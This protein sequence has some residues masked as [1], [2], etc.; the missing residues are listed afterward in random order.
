MSKNKNNP[1]LI[2]AAILALYGSGLNHKESSVTK[3]FFENEAKKA[4]AKASVKELGPI[5]PITTEKCEQIQN[6]IDEILAELNIQNLEG[7][8]EVEQKEAAFKLVQY[9]N[10]NTH[11][12][13]RLNSE[14]EIDKLHPVCADINLM[15][16]ALC[17]GFDYGNA[18]TLTIN[19][20]YQASGLNS[21]EIT[22]QKFTNNHTNTFTAHELIAVK[23]GDKE[24]VYDPINNGRHVNSKQGNFDTVFTTA[25]DYF[26]KNQDYKIVKESA[27]V[28]LNNQ[29]VVT[30]IQNDLT[31]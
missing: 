4:E 13:R 12:A 18:E 29:L 11:H 10:N 19:L 3:H 28:V 31:M 26:E 30:N 24:Y 6:K 22:V 8:S 23:I 14:D 17:K 20:L 27:P 1:M 15:H 2:I 25:V 9:Y 21:K 7:K 16:K 5:N